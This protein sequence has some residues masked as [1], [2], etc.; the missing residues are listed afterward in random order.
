MQ[1]NHITYDQQGRMTG[2]SDGRYR[3]SFFYDNNGNR[4][5]VDSTYVDDKGELIHTDAFNT[6]DK[7]N[8]QLF[9]NAENSSTREVPVL[10]IGK[11]GHKLT[12]D[13]AG[14]R[15]SDEYRL[16]PGGAGGAI[17]DPY[18][19][20]NARRLTYTRQN[21]SGIDLRTYDDAGRLSRSGVVSGTDGS[22]RTFAYDAAGKVVRQKER[23]NKNAPLD[24]IYYKADSRF[25]TTGYDAAG[26]MT[27]YFV[28]PPW[29]N[30]D[31][32]LW[33]SL[34]YAHFDDY[35]QSGV[36]LRRCADSRTTISAHDQNGNRAG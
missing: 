6:Y 27:G 34:D 7:M 25:P 14:N 5:E 22:Y 8:R 33:Y 26:H 3:V 15:K 17:T 12:Y 32:Q 9:V 36:T 23:T 30:T 24:D 20:D 4:T 2:V 29:T 1:N 18:E 13:D 16:R 35:R 11:Y 31:E 28:V 21:G 19:Y 10:D